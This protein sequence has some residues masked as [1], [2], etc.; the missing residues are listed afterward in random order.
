MRTRTITDCSSSEIDDLIEKEYGQKFNFAYHVM[1]RSY[2]CRVD[3]QEMEPELLA[4][5][6]KVGVELFNDWDLSQ[7][8]L[9]EQLLCDL[10]FRGRLIAGDYLIK[11]DD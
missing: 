5:F 9:E 10:C 3:A 11:F 1:D 6:K 8:P 4:K 7:P 2:E